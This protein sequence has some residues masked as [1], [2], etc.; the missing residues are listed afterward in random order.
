M[1]MKYTIVFVA[2]GALALAACSSDDGGSAHVS[3]PLPTAPLGRTGEPGQAE[4][5]PG[6][7]SEPGYGNGQDLPEVNLP[8]SVV[9][10]TAPVYGE[11]DV[12]IEQGLDG[13][14]DEAIADLAQRLDVPVADITVVAARSVVWPDGSIGCPQPDMLYTQVQVDGAWVRLAFDGG[15]YAYHTGGSRGLFLCE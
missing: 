15:T 5:E 10:P 11:G 14:I 2:L 9:K 7:P 8:R 4:Y 13:V 1:G 12:V 3:A 6:D